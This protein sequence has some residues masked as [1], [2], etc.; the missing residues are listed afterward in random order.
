M[1][2]PTQHQPCT[3]SSSQHHAADLNALQLNSADHW[4]S[5]ITGYW[6]PAANHTLHFNYVMFA[7]SAGTTLLTFLTTISHMAASSTAVLC[8]T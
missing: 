3:A 7:V 8:S 2:P 6:Q 4:L 5:T 1:L